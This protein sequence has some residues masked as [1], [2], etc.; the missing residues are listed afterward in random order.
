MQAS[1]NNPAC[2]RRDLPHK[3][4]LSLLDAT[5]STAILCRLNVGTRFE[6][7]LSAGG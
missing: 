5:V 6:R 7:L 2:R 3:A 4:F 1:G